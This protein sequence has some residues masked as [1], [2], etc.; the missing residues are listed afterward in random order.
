MYLPVKL[1][2]A[3][4]SKRGGWLLLTGLSA[5]F[6]Y[7]P[8]EAQEACRF[9]L[10]DRTRGYSQSTRVDAD[11]FIH[12]FSGGVTRGVIYSCADGVQIL[13]DSAALFERDGRAELFGSVNFSDADTELQARRAIY[14]ANNRQLNAWEDIRLL[15]R[16]NGAVITGDE[17]VLYRATTFR[18][19]DRMV[20]TGEFPH[21]TVFLPDGGIEAA[22]PYEVDARR[23]ILE[24][25]RFFRAGGGVIVTRVTLNA[26][27]DSLDFDQGLG[28]MSVFTDARVADS[29]FDLT[30]QTV[31]VLTPNGT[32]EEV[33]AREDAELDGDGVFLEAP[34]IRMFVRDNLVQRLV[35]L[36]T[37]PP[38]PTELTEWNDDPPVETVSDS[39]LTVEVDSVALSNAAE[40][41][42][43]DAAAGT[44]ESLALDSVPEAD[45]L[46]QPSATTD[47]F[48]LWADSIDIRS[49]DQALERL[50]AVG[51]AKGESTTSDAEADVEDASGIAARDWMEGDTIVLAFTT[52]EPGVAVAQDSA[53]DRTLVSE[54]RRTTVESI[55]SSGTA[56]S[57]YRLPPSDT[58][59]APAGA[60]PALHYV[61]ASIIRIFMVEGQVTRMEVEGETS[62]FHFEPNPLSRPDSASASPEPFLEA[63]PD[64]GMSSM[65]NS[66]AATLPNSRPT[67]LHL[68]RKRPPWNLR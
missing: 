59:T 39:S 25:R 26:V 2:R 13:A 35:A 63:R 54:E 49:P 16:E 55:T 40:L 17:M 62:G 5:L 43:V 9:N 12:Y 50:I 47:E 19:M 61:K 14:Y 6:P 31:T 18:P 60:S 28:V 44:L 45:T 30:A 29:N 48:Q 66:K 32:T 22:I 11:N 7:Q 53:G 27:G 10:Q 24:G 20:I 41:P 3:W 52:S 67:P 46:P 37:V 58:M 36:R 56:R 4:G 34:A 65:G 33:V 38:I 42:V 1:G 64:S 51:T 21:A 68:R 15:D 8:L 23:F 57:F